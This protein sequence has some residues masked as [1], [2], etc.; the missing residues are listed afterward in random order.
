LEKLIRPGWEKLK[1]FA[2]MWG[3]LIQW[4]E[5]HSLQCFYVKYFGVHCP[6]CGFQRGLILLMKG[7]L[8]ASIKMYP[9]LIP[10][11]FMFGFL[12]LHLFQHFE[13]GGAIL[14]NSFIF[15]VSL[16]IL[17]YFLKL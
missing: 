17:N 12:V 8:W 2:I 15:V 9:P 14:K 6:G 5:E 7:E 1:V 16:M 10:T 4:L 3:T 13:R 11:L